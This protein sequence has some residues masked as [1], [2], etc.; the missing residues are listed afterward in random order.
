MGRVLAFE[1][2][3]GNWRLTEKKGAP[4]SYCVAAIPEPKY[5]RTF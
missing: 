2:A 5:G 3:T 4:G 1:A